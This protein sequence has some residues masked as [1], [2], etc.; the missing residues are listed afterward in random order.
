MQLL[1]LICLLILSLS[2][3]ITNL[4]APQVVINLDL[5]PEDR[6]DEAI[7]LVISTHGWDDSFGKVF[8]FSF[9]KCI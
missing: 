1:L 4:D 7:E 8:F 9:Y 2:Y 6:W 5:P 3:S